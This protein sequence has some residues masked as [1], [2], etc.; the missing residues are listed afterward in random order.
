MAIQSLSSLAELIM[1]FS[2]SG[3]TGDEIE[4][5]GMCQTRNRSPYNPANTPATTS[6]PGHSLPF[7]ANSSTSHT[8]PLNSPRVNFPGTV[9]EH[10]SHAE[11]REASG[12]E[13]CVRMSFTVVPVNRQPMSSWL[14]KRGKEE[15]TYR[16]SSHP[17]PP[18]PQ[19]NHPPSAASPR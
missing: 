2:N 8:I 17:R 15:A 5:L 3:R 19:T 10:R 13:Y 12:S 9:R 1:R 6:P 18:S 4:S 14:D 11:A 16:P 7:N